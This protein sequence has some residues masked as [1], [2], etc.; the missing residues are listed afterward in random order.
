MRSLRVAFLCAIFSMA[1]SKDATSQHSPSWI[2]ST[3]ACGRQ[4]LTRMLDTYH[5]ALVTREPNRLPLARDVRFTENGH[6]LRI[7]EGLWQSNL[8]EGLYRINI[9]DPDSG[10]ASAST[11]LYQGNDTLQFLVRLTVRDTLIREIETLIA[12]KGDTCCWSPRSL[13]SL[14]SVF[15]EDEPPSARMTRTELLAIMDGYFTA[16]QTGG[17]ADYRRANVDDRTMRWENGQQT[18]NVPGGNVIIRATV[19]VQL[20]RGMFAPLQVANRRYLVID[21]EK[22][23]A[24]AIVLFLQPNRRRPTT[25]IAEFF[26]I[27]SGT[28]REIRAVMVGVDPTGWR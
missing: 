10:T 27:S 11:V 25:I 26:K 14:S 9:V 16:L 6:V 12:R 28:I 21:P 5:T 19:P 1:L 17:S 24:L 7:G 4:C 2:A 20:D 18:T 3:N 8:R 15:G 13:D 23:T 22:G